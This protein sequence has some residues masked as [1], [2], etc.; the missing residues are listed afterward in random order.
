MPYDSDSEV[1]L[2][3]FCL[4]GTYWHGRPVMG[5]RSNLIIPNLPNFTSFSDGAYILHS[6]PISIMF[7]VS[8]SDKISLKVSTKNVI[9]STSSVVAEKYE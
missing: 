1:H 5:G 4:G 3:G 8:K 9:L 7:S 6:A 2:Y